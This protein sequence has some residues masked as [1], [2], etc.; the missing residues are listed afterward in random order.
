MC[1][2]SQEGVGCA[3]VHSWIISASQ[4]AQGCSKNPPRHSPALGCMH[5]ASTPL[6]L[7]YLAGQV[8]TLTATGVGVFRCGEDPINGS[9]L[10]SFPLWS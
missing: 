10:Y 6:F 8:P 7:P 3:V 1:C 4:L 2:F 9:L 5:I